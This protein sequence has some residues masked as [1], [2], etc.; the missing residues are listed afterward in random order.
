METDQDSV[1]ANWSGKSCYREALWLDIN[2]LNHK[3]T[4][5]ENSKVALMTK[6]AC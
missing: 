1:D 4:N 6:L 5:F 2:R 3:M